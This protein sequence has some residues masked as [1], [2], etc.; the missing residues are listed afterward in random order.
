MIAA[1]AVPSE[2]ALSAASRLATRMSGHSSR[3]IPAE[4][5][6]VWM[7]TCVYGLIAMTTARRRSWTPVPVKS[8]R[9][10]N[11]YTVGPSRT[12]APGNTAYTAPG[13]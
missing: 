11:A 12:S 10:T 6:I 8:F 13:C 5:R 9:T 1:A 2:T 3:G 4:E 7:L